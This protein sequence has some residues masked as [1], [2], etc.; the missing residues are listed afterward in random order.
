MASMARTPMSSDPKPQAAA[1]RDDHPDWF[2]Q[3]ISARCH[4]DQKVAQKAAQHG[5]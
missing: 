4:L 1:G 3:V 2:T 5:L